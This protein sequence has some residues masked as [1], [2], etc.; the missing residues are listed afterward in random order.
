MTSADF[1][2]VVATPCDVGSSAERLR[3]P[4]RVMRT[5]LHA[6]ACRIYARTFRADFGLQRYWPP[7]PV[8]APHAVPVRQASVLPWAS[9]PRSPRDAAVALRLDLPSAG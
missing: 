6:Y 7:Y 8:R 2:A 3:R 4:P 1:C 9:F 5:C